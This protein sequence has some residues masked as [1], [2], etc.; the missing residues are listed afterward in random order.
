MNY[1]YYTATDFVTDP[2]FRS[3]ILEQDSSAAAFWENWMKENPD[4]REELDEARALLYVLAE[5]EL[6]VG[7]EELDGRVTDL[8]AHIGG[9]TQRTETRMRPALYRY[10]GIAASICIVTGLSWLGYRSME[11]KPA[12][13]RAAA[14]VHENTDGHVV[15]FNRTMKP[16]TILLEDSSVVTLEPQSELTF[17]EKFAP[18][19][20]EVYLKGEAFFQISHNPE[21]PF[22][23]KTNELVTRVLGTSFTV[24]SFE[25]DRNASVSVITGRVSVYSKQDEPIAD[26]PE[27]VIGV[28]LKPNQRV[29]FDKQESRLMKVIVDVP[30]RVREIPAA[31]LVFDE[32]PVKNVFK[33]LEKEYGIELFF[34]EELLSDCQLTANISGLPM[35]EQLDLICRII[36]A[37]YEVVDGQVIIHGGGCKAD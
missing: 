7:A 10:W 17:P 11:T 34:N 22:L 19:K 37:K 6:Y 2:S 14:S 20:R 9:H 27:K 12:S 5:K 28:V 36:H 3:W 18:E 13:L 24:R 21:R 23:V 25:K 15:R 31:S 35:Y 30:L 16:V 26:A 32:A 4:R 29:L 1:R 33:T 8:L